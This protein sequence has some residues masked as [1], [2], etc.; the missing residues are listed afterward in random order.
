L[1]LKME[2]TYSSKTSVYFQWT[3]WCY[4]PEDGT[5]HNHCSDNLK[6]YDI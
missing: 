2:A 4:S 3:T 5:L 1:I 6:S